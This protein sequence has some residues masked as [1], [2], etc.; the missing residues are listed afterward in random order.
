MRA[1]KEERVHFSFYAIDRKANVVYK[2][3]TKGNEALGCQSNGLIG[4]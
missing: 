2:E 4:F 1:D 3:S